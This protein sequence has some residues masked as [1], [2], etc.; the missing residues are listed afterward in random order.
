MLAR[1]GLVLVVISIQAS[2]ND[3]ASRPTS[4]GQSSRPVVVSD[5]ALIGDRSTPDRAVQSWWTLLDR[6]DSIDQV[7]DSTDFSARQNVQLRNAVRAYLG[8]VAL[9][10]A[11]EE[12]VPYKHVRE[13]VDVDQE[14]TT[15]AT[16]TTKIRNVT[17]IPP[18]ATPDEYD[19]RRRREGETVRY[20]LEKDSEG[21][22]ITQ[23]KTHSDVLDKWYDRYSATPSV[24]SS[25]TSY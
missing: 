6:A 19:V 24:P 16:V 18:G 2:C 7:V 23:V 17:P 14:T 21:W 8:G 13:I 15:R 25:I 1:G 5:S 11:K 22:K 10:S 12:D 3:A 4:A 9:A 20:F